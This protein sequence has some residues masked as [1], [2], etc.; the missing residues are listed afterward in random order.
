V[1]GWRVVGT[2]YS[3][4]LPGTLEWRGGVLTGDPDALRDIGEIVA[5]G[6]DVPVTP[7][8]PYL[9]A[10]PNDEK[11]ALVMAWNVMRCCEFTG[12]PPVI[13]LPR[14]PKGAIP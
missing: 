8:G 13:R 10:D 4:G 6:R 14:L 11:S 12:D 3:T 1:T 9:T 2:L 5:S 7:T